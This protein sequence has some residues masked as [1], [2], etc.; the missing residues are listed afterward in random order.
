MRKMI[1]GAIGLFFLIA[2]AYYFGLY[3]NGKINNENINKVLLD[4]NAVEESS[5]KEEKKTSEI[6]I[7]A[8]GD[9]LVHETQ[10]QAQFNKE[11]KQYDF[12]NNFKYVKPYIKN[13][14]LAIANLETV[15]GGPEKGYTGYPTFNSPDSI[16][17]ALKDTGF[18]LLTTANNHALD[19]GSKG[20]FRTNNILREKSIDYIGSKASSQDNSFIVKDVEGIKVGVSNYTF[21]TAK[22]GGNKTI[23]SVKIPKEV[24]GLIDTFN[25][26][27]FKEDIPRIKERIKVMKEKGAEVIIFCMHWGEEYQRQPNKQQK[28]IAQELANDG[29]DIIL[30]GHPHVLQP[31]EYIKSKVDDRE[32]LVV[33]SMGNFISNQRYEILKQ[34]YSEDGIIVNIKIK[35]DL[36]ANKISI[37]DVTYVPTW[38][39]RYSKNNNFVYEIVPLFDALSNKDKFN[40]FNEETVSRAEMSKQSTVSLIDSASTKVTHTLGLSDAAIEAMSKR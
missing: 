16:V 19:G 36:N 9:I 15:L 12:T 17:D 30:G 20:F 28:D 2:L 14:N 37:E 21:E 10:L 27:G 8:V 7:S 5:K 26:Q 13:A 4:T 6:L 31:I 18:N 35:K 33:Y 3:N 34:R 1:S 32:T 29:V 23:N 25:Y 38:V 40:L 24:E 11:T 22:T 39:N